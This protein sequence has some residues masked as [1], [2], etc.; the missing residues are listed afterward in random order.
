MIDVIQ[1]LQKEGELC[2]FLFT[3]KIESVIVV[4]TGSK[5]RSLAHSYDQPSHW[6]VDS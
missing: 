4:F 6:S 3:I 1:L 5:T 2:L